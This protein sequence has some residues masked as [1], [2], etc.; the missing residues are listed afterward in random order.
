MSLSNEVA[1]S[2][3]VLL[4]KRSSHELVV[5]FTVFSCSDGVRIASSV[6]EV[7]LMLRALAGCLRCT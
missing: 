4:G 5:Y 3:V 7:M 1:Y 6:D 2:K